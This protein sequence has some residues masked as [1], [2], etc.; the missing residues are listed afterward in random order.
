M[1][2]TKIRKPGRAD[3]VDGI[4]GTEDQER[5]EERI[6]ELLVEVQRLAAL[7]RTVDLCGTGFVWTDRATGK[8]HMLHPADVA[9]ILRADQGTEIEKIKESAYR[10]GREDA[11]REMAQKIIDHANRYAPLDGNIQQRRM[12]RHLMIAV[13]V[14]SPKPSL[15]EI[16][17]AVARGDYVACHL[18]EYGQ[19]VDQ[20]GVQP[21]EEQRAHE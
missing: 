19:P 5:D 10:A 13:Q 8:Q 16:A 7:V 21:T 1:I 20:P 4:T 9:V 14:V 15:E 12:R 3:P 18:D 6:A 2:L 17:A 11:A